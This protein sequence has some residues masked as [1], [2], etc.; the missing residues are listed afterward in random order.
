MG[1]HDSA[2]MASQLLRTTARRA[3]A[4]LRV[5]VRMMSGIEERGGAMEDQ[6]FAKREA[7][8]LRKL[9]KHT[10]AEG[11]DKPIV[12][13]YFVRVSSGKVDNL[14]V[15]AE[16]DKII[17]NEII[18]LT[19]TMDGFLGCDRQVC[20]KHL[21]YKL[22]SKWD[23]AENLVASGN[24]SDYYKHALTKVADLFV[25]GEVQ[26]QNFMADTEKFS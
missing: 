2:A 11:E 6:Y 3:P 23:S 9:R 4:A 7:E 20:G 19:K 1:T 5:P 21:D 24:A 12:P 10:V 22:I 25:N 26:T 13:D 17:V 16:V 8:M 15:A 18:P 14:H